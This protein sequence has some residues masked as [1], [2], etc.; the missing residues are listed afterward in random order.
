MD[1]NDRARNTIAT[2]TEFLRTIKPLLPLIPIGLV[3]VAL[4]IAG[5][6]AFHGTDR[7]R[8]FRAAA[9]DVL[10]G[11]AILG[12]LVLTLSPSS[13]AGRT[14]DLV[15]LDSSSSAQRA[16]NVLL[17][18][19][20]GVFVPARWPVFDGWARAILAGAATSATIEALQFA[21]GLG[22]EA[23]STDVILNT[24]GAALGYLILRVARLGLR[25]PTKTG[26]PAR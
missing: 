9:L 20:L 3:V 7:R 17:F 6:G 5:L 16:G 26:S 18:V 15:P 4:A 14:I 11:A 19:P 21:L 2:V 23:S 1:P 24:G 8:A 10:V 12:V 25:R 22:R 13:D